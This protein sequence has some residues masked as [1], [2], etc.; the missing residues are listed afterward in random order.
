[1]YKD[2]NWWGN[3]GVAVDLAA[4]LRGYVECG[5]E[6]RPNFADSPATIADVN[7]DGSPEVVVTGNVYNCGTDPYT[8]LYEGVFIFNA[9]R[10]RFNQNGHNWETVPTN[11][12]APVSED[13]NV[14]ESAMPNPVVVDI[15]GDGNKEILYP[16][17]DGKLHCFWL[18]KTEKYNWPY[19]IYKPGEDVLRFASEPVVV[20]LDN[21]GEAEIIFTSWTQ[22]SSSLVGKLH[23]LDM[24]GNPLHEIDLPTSGG[25]NGALPA[26]TVADIDGDGDLEIVVNTINSGIVVYHLPNTK[27]ARILW[28]T[29]RGNFRRTGSNFSCALDSVRISGVGFL[30]ISNAYV[31]AASG[32]T[33]QAHAQNFTENINLTNSIPITL[34]GGYDCQFLSNSG[35]TTVT[36]KVTVQNGQVTMDKIIIK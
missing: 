12:G 13:Y 14:I 27:N 9:D 36:G 6:H 2:M 34:R 17:Y 32:H 33:I 16:A 15:D 26:P 22:K 28:G 3:V 7:N 23:I 1:M 24:R 10:S 5:T 35:Y 11:V 19:S 4:E 30:S 8:S 29:G 20:D 18:D 31:A 21:D 25:W